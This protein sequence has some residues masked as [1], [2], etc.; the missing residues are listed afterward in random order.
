MS[1]LVRWNVPFAEAFY[2]SVIAT[3]A[4]P[5]YSVSNSKTSVTVGA[6]DGA[7]YLVECET[8]LAFSC[9]DESCAPQRDFGDTEIE[10]VKSCA[11][12]WI[13]SPWIKSYEGC[14]YDADAQ[15]IPLNHFFIYGGDN[16]VE[17]LC[18]YEPVI[19]K[20]EKS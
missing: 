6:S 20:L 18:R 3:F 4:T 9:L 12:Q 7:N 5:T 14:N 2:P 11:W 8:T 10:D 1:K 16:I 13:D 17:F 19:T 15:P